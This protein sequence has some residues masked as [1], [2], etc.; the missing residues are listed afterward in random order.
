M[1]MA[2][3]S[4]S[5]GEPAPEFEGI[6]TDDKFVNNE[7]IKGKWTV[8]FF[9]PKAFTPGCTKEVCNL[10]DNY[11]NLK[12][13]NINIYGI[14]RDDIETQK[15]FKEEHNL[16]YELISDK[17]GKIIKAF[18]VSGFGGLA[19]RKTFILSP[20]GKIAYIFNKVNPDKHASEVE[21]VLKKL[22]Q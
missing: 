1:L 17:D 13:Y 18:G 6:A 21:E 14:S 2:V 16:P 22:I 3:I 12:K 20:D 19:Q 10:R 9:Y 4:L 15:K 5:V 8:L 7:T 11:S